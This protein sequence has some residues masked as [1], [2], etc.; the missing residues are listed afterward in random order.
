[1]SIALSSLRRAMLPPVRMFVRPALG[2]RLSP[3][4][5]A[6]AAAVTPVGGPA[7]GRPHVDPSKPLRVALLGAGGVS[8]LHRN[9]LAALPN[10]QLKGMFGLGDRRELQQTAADY[11][12]TA[13]A[14][15]DALINDPAYEMHRHRPCTP[16]L[17]AVRVEIALTCAPVDRLF[18]QIGCDLG[19]DAYGD[20]L[21]VRVRCHARGQT[22]ICGE[23]GRFVSVRAV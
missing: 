7:I 4:M 3:R 16:L 13:Y 12:T 19:V 15:A 22:R 17:D 5:M 21:R 1:M 18:P 14:S 9:A 8:V 23:A 20:A 6:T 2:V 10:V 11:K